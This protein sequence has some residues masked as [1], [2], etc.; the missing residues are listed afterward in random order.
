MKEVDP[1]STIF[2]VT[3]NYVYDTTPVATAA[4][5]G[6]KGFVVMRKGGDAGIYRKNPATA[7]GWNHDIN[8][9]QA[10]IGRRPGDADGAVSPMIL[11]WLSHRH[12]KLAHPGALFYHF[13]IKRSICHACLNA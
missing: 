2:A 3:A 6:D 5:Y 9:F 1:S 8:K 7:A 13:G 4:P 10:S 12:T 11:P